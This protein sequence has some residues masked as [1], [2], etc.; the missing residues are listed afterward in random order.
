MTGTR[1]KHLRPASPATVALADAGYTQA[2]L[3][4]F[5]DVTVGAVS[6]W[7][8]GERSGPA[9]ARLRLVVEEHLPAKHS[10]EV[11]AAIPQKERKAA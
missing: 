4:N 7:L 8:R 1:K 9:G 2:D 11:L 6:R 5:A 3:A 10:S